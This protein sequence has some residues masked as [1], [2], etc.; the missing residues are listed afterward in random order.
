MD[1]NH[2][3]K[4]ENKQTTTGDKSQLPLLSRKD[5]EVAQKDEKEA[6]KELVRLRKGLRKDRKKPKQ[7][8]IIVGISTAIVGALVLYYI[9]PRFNLPM[10]VFWWV[11]ILIPLILIGIGLLPLLFRRGYTA[12]WTG[13]KGK[14][15]WDWLNL[16]GTLAIPIVVVV[17]TIGLG[18]WQ[19]QGAQDQQQATTL[20]T[21]IDNIQDL[22]L[23]NNLLTSKPSDD[24]AIIARARTQIALKS[25]DRRGKGLLI[26]FLYEA[27]L[28]GFSD[29]VTDKKT[30]KSVYTP[31]SAIISLD[32][33]D[34]SE[35]ILPRSGSFINRLDGIDLA[36]AN[37]NGADLSEVS[38][39]EADLSGTQLEDANLTNTFLTQQQLDQVNLC[40]GAILPKGL[41]CH[42]N[43]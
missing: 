41:T 38:L 3:D 20:Q 14:T 26:K 24:V 8:P 21:Y 34:L 31:H 37:L 32:G 17:A 33:A 42:H 43:Q 40:K 25:L 13:M 7:L 1:E 19:A 39:D 5:E 9:L 12:Q 4:T 35:M 6:Q 2:Q 23:K 10:S 29:K 15:L 22:L 27:R 18:W 16:S 28:I 36:G 30:N 11:L